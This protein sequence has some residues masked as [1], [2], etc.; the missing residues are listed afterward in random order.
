MGAVSF[1]S[2]VSSPAVY[3]AGL[4]REQPNACLDIHASVVSS[5]QPTSC[6]LDSNS[7]SRLAGQIQ[8]NTLF[9]ENLN[10]ILQRYNWRVQ[11]N[12]DGVAS[13]PPHLE[14]RKCV[15]TKLMQAM[16]LECTETYENTSINNCWHSIGP[17]SSVSDAKQ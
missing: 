2:S 4:E 17:N 8:Q 6:T 15:S 16:H 3:G 1:S 10:P 9:L 13:S 5:I 14:N 12:S 11:H 7:G